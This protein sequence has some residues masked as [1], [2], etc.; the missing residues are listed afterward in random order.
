MNTLIR[1]RI[2]SWVILATVTPLMLACTSTTPELDARFGDAVRAAREQQTLNPQPAG[3]RDPV[4][5]I[6]GKAA[7]SAQDRYQESFKAP[8]KTFEV[9][10]I[11]GTASGQ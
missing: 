2:A 5:G 6:D 8:P 9:L 3:T 7:V 11:G 1:Q 4:S 10:G